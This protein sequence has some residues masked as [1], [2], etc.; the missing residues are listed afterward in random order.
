MYTIYCDDTLIYTDQSHD[1]KYKLLDATLHLEDNAA[2]TLDLSLPK[3]NIG[4]S[5]IKKMVSHIVV[6]RNDEK[7]FGGRAITESYDFDM[8]RQLTCEGELAYLND[9]Y[10]PGKDWMEHSIVSVREYITAILSVHNNKCNGTRNYALPNPS[11]SVNQAYVDYNKYS[12]LFYT[13]E[14]T[15]KTGFLL[16]SWT[17]F[18]MTETAYNQQP[19]YNEYATTIGDRI[20]LPTLSSTTDNYRNYRIQIDSYLS[21]YISSDD[22]PGSSL[23]VTVY[24]YRFL[25]RLTDD[26]FKGVSDY[27]LTDTSYTWYLPIKTLTETQIQLGVHMEVA[28]QFALTDNE[29]ERRNNI[30][31]IT[32]EDLTNINSG[33]NYFSYRLLTNRDEFDDPLYER[34]DFVKGAYTGH[35][36]GN[37]FSDSG[38]YS[39]YATSKVNS[40][41]SNTAIIVPTL[42][43]VTEDYS[44]YSIFIKA[45]P[46]EYSYDP[47]TTYNN[48]V[49][50]FKYRLL[51]KKSNEAATET[52]V[53]DWATDST[54]Y[55]RL[56]SDITLTQAEINSHVTVV[57]R[58]EVTKL[59]NVQMSTL[60]IDNL[61]NGINYF[62]VRIADNTNLDSYE[63]QS[64]IQ[65]DHRDKRI[66]TGAI[67]FPD[68]LPKDFAITPYQ[69]TLE[70]LK[71]VVEKFKGHVRIRTGHDGKLYLDYL[72]DYINTNT[73]TIE[74]SKNLID[75]TQEY[76]L[77]EFSTVLLPLGKKK[78]DEAKVGREIMVHWNENSAIEPN[79][80]IR[81]GKYFHITNWI[82]VKNSELEGYWDSNG[83]YATREVATQLSFIGE[84]INGYPMYA[85]YDSQYRLLSSANANDGAFDSQKFT[86]WTQI[87]IPQDATFVV[88]GFYYGGNGGFTSEGGTPFTSDSG[89]GIT[90]IPEMPYTSTR[91]YDTI[92]K[93]KYESVSTKYEYTMNDA[94]RD[95]H[96]STDRVLDTSTT[97]YR[98]IRPYGDEYVVSDPIIIPPTTDKKVTYF[99]TSRMDKGHGIYTVH[100]AN[101]SPIVS[102]KTASNDG[103]VPTDNKKQPIECPIGSRKIYVAGK[104]NVSYDPHVYYDVTMTSD[105]YYQP[106][107]EYVTIES[108]NGGS[109]Y[110]EHP[111]LINEYGWIEKT[112]QFEEADT[113]AK[114]KTMAN[115]YMRTSMFDEMTLT[116]KAL[117]LHILKADVEAI[118]LYDQIRCV[119]PYHK[120]DKYFPVV[121]IELPILSPEDQIFTLT[122]NKQN[123]TIAGNT[124]ND[125]IEIYKR[126]EDVPDPSAVLI[127]A[128][129]NATEIMN[130]SNNGF[131]YKDDHEI[132]IMDTPSKETATRMWRFNVN[133]I[134]YSSNGYSGPFGLAMTMDGAIVADRITTGY[135]HADRIRG[136]S[137]TL[138]GYDGVD[139]EFHMLNK[140]GKEFIKMTYEG[141]EF[142]ASISTPFE[143]RLETTEL[144]GVASFD[145][146]KLTGY[147]ASVAESPF[148]SDQSSFTSR[149]ISFD[150]IGNK[151]Q[152]TSIDLLGLFKLNNASGIGT[153]YKGIKMETGEAFFLTANASSFTGMILKDDSFEVW[154]GGSRSNSF[155]GTVQF[156]KSITNNGDG[157]ISWVGSTAVIKD[158]FVQLIDGSTGDGGGSGG[159]G[160]GGGGDTPTQTSIVQAV[161]LSSGIKDALISVFNK[162][163][164]SD[165]Q[166]NTY[167]AAMRTALENNNN[168]NVSVS[169]SET[170]ELV[171]ISNAIKTALLNCFDNV[172]W[173]DGNGNSHYA[174]I[175]N[176]L[177]TNYG[178]G[179]SSNVTRVVGL[180]S[181]LKTALLNCFDHAAWSN[182]NGD[183]YYTALQTA[184]NTTST[185]SGG[186]GGFSSG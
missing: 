156:I 96:I 23:R 153:Q 169:S 5:M 80:C 84:Q 92:F 170:L 117:D 35:K 16:G 38:E 178:S 172:A 129:N 18:D 133:G 185:S 104:K 112:M 50:K 164:W 52:R 1:L 106:L 168:T 98:E 46:F 121:E 21:K 63:K 53:T 123:K 181:E 101:D 150:D 186:D 22:N 2:G 176:G 32:D 45:F 88:F 70:A 78:D 51:Y 94:S 86:T 100:G 141:A 48:K 142:L 97:Y 33:D 161:S 44:K 180:T 184:L 14:F 135:M 90:S 159:G 166:G 158:G 57:C 19:P 26:S 25:Y 8:N 29:I 42:N 162:M 65:V 137:L 160:G 20:V 109:L 136:G 144:V 154:R 149:Q 157:T 122:L 58:I 27:W 118:D 183:T 30:A 61:S 24:K 31:L 107:D 165:S 77:S 37:V 64:Q 83:N 179:S 59:E 151:T 131:V 113:P 49:S 140:E 139:G 110:L 62:Q 54:Y 69:S 71:A 163:A 79:G 95:I 108:V 17:N 119:S 34:A 127:Q 147:T 146:G 116:I 81:Y 167:Y 11:N 68:F 99:Y 174:T 155:S 102:T 41:S 12:S 85:F 89:A 145:Q 177:N 4:Y 152:V 39:A 66:Y 28:V 182:S 82:S 60:D 126:L 143:R 175:Q 47:N 91:V 115:E 10:Q 9:T 43:N 125:S 128:R 76:N 87:N 13:P 15:R 7:I 120:L 134:G 171:G 111:N 55:F 114:L 138:G 73:Q 124:V 40:G 132:L 3:T 103:D 130:L 6:Y 75:H 173:S 74:I 72:K 67:F 105:A 148:I 56:P 93:I 36:I